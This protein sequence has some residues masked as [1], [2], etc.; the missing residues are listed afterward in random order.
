ML[1]TYDVVYHTN[2][3]DGVKLEE[4]CQKLDCRTH[5]QKSYGVDVV[6]GER[7]KRASLF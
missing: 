2:N 6:G 3:Y 5:L 4:F 1:E 7:V